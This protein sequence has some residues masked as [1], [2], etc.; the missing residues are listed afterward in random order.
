MG[1]T[2]RGIIGRKREVEGRKRGGGEEAGYYFKGPMRVV[3]QGNR[4]EGISRGMR[5]VGR[6]GTGQKGKNHSGGG[7]L[8]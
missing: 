2:G 4:N 8:T 1:I 7:V 5:E 3:V 6:S